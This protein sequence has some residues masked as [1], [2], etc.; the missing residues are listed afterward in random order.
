MS[1]FS[2]FHTTNIILYDNSNYSF[3][4]SSPE[5]MFCDV[6]TASKILEAY[7]K[8]PVLG[9]HPLTLEMKSIIDEADKTKK[10]R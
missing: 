6:P 1:A 3:V 4:R 2:I 5:A 7:R 10:G 9:F 8:L